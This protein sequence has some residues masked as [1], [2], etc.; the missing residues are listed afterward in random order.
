[1]EIV[2]VIR[3]RLIASTEEEAVAGI[4]EDDILTGYG[5]EG[6]GGVD[7]RYAFSGDI[8]EVVRPPRK[9]LAVEAVVEEARESLGHA[10]VGIGDEPVPGTRDALEAAQGADGKAA[11][12]LDKEIHCEA[13]RRVALLRGCLHLD[14]GEARLR[15]CLV[16]HPKIFHL[17]HQIF[18]TC[19][20]H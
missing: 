14:S 20:E 16:S 5:Q 3:T 6:E 12:D 1:M 13:V 10:V 15:P 7:E 19:I 9:S 11:E 17:S 4:S 8:G 18:N 2:A